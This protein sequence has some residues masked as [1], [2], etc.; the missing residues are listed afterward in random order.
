MDFR[1]SEEQQLIRQTARDFAQA[2]IAPVAA[3]IDQEERFPTE[4]VRQ[5]GELGLLGMN[6]PP[7]FGGGGADFVSHALAMEE[8][9]RACA[10]HGVIMSVN[11]SLVSWPISQYGSDDQR[12]R[13][14]PELTSGRMVGSFSLSEPGSGSDAAGLQAS[15]VADGNDY[16]LNGTKAWVS[17]GGQAG[18]YLVFCRT[19]RA[20]KHRGIS[21]LLVER[22]TPGLLAGAKEKTMGIR[23]SSTV[24]LSF[25]DARVPKSNLLGAEGQGFQIAMDTLDGGRFGIAA[26][27]VGVAQVCLDEALRYAQE[28]CAFDQPIGNFQAVRFMLADMA[29]NI[30]AARWLTLHA[31]FCRDSGEPFTKWGSMAKLFASRTAVECADSNLQIHGGVGYTRD[32]PAERHYRDAKILEIYEG[33]S[34]IQRVVIA[35]RL[36]GSET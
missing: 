21:C 6:V 1:L 26:Q 20:S 36:L 23:A 18:V 29:T 13:F 3:E 2:H 22:D 14:L 8:V 31:A 28:R 10:A 4:T 24:Q 5:L 11:N 17:N 19:D 27:A 7:E 33:T 12:R 32:F 16:I 30:Q 34:Q 15:A 9:S 25:T 35:D